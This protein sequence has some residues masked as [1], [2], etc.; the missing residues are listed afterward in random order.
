MSKWIHGFLDDV[1]SYQKAGGTPSVSNPAFYDGYIPFVLIEDMTN[2][3]RFLTKTGKTLTLE[4]LNNSSAWLVPKEHILY[5][6]YATVG[7]PVINKIDCA[8]NQA[9]I[10]LKA[11]DKVHDN[12]LFYW[13][14]YIKP[15]VWRYTTQTTQ[16]NL[17]AGIVRRLPISYPE[18][19]SIQERISQILTLV[20]DAIEK[21]QCLIRK[22]KKIKNGM[23]LDLLTRGVNASGELRG[24]Y[25]SA[26]H[27]YKMS[28]LGYIPKNWSVVKLEELLSPIANNFRS[29][30]FGSA[31]L[32]S[33]LV[34][35]GI[36]FLGIDN[37]HVEYF[38]NTFRR[39][40]SERKFNELLKYAVRPR[41]VVIT[42]MGTVGRAAVIPSDI[43][44]ALSSKHLWTM[45]F[46]ESLIVPELVC[47]QLN[48]AP[49]VKAWFRKETQG[50]IMDAIQSKTL[51]SLELPLPGKEEQ[52]QLYEKYS[53]VTKKLKTEE[54][55]LKK[56]IK[57]KNGLMHDL[58]TGKVPVHSKD[59]EA[60]HV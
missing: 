28:S 16:S 4:G 7:K 8:T 55:S 14:E 10:A 20:D 31:L 45:T 6:M 59:T 21:T 24:S 32:K 22:Y 57:E 48:H 2:S 13:L 1:T 12:Y 44:R 34:E 36:P 43:E 50:G 51:R 26:P 39:F 54:I 9:I 17:N 33:E 30:P 25:R 41:D 56:L 42:I 19:K 18:N 35:K 53:L 27:L 49:W 40:V 46:N 60:P 47:W 5:S 38:D 58:L 15:S 37:I 29:G 23:M 11:N 3:Y 52:L